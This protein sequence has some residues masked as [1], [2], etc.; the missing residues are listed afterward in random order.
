MPELT[1]GDVTLHYETWGD[2]E[3]PAV[4]LLHGFTADHRMWKPNVDALSEDFHVI[5]PDL[6]GHGLT[7]APEDPAEYS[8][9]AY[10]RDLLALLDGLGADLCALVGCS[11]GGMIALDFVCH[12]PGRVA[13]LVISDSSPAPASERYGEEFRERERRMLESETIV[14]RF[15]TAE[16]GKRM[17]ADVKDRFLAEGLRRRV[18][19]MRAEGYVGASLMRRERPD[20][21][22]L[23][24][25]R[26]TMPLLLCIGDRDPARSG[27]EVIAEEVPGARVVTFRETGHGVPTLRPA[28]FNETVLQFFRDIE[29]GKPVSGRKTIT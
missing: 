9:E 16:L 22:P 11:F 12:V 5:A 13:A 2:P 28:A 1:N 24:G 27:M 29:D 4:V 19:G 7:S 25:E 3:S 14:R 18:A 15:G 23:L 6:R 21:I 26:I 20:L 10:R 8:T 17:A